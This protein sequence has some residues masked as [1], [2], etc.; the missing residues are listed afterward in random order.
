MRNKI[1]RLILYNT[2]GF[3]KNFWKKI[4]KNFSQISQKKFFLGNFQKFRVRHAIYRFSR[5]RTRCNR[6]KIVST[7]RYIYNRFCFPKFTFSPIRLG[8]GVNLTPLSISAGKVRDG[9][10]MVQ[11]DEKQVILTNKTVLSMVLGVLGRF[12]EV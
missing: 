5:R 6:L 9:P 10:Q 3:F 2:I 12:L 4:F 11:M 7:T 1:T 8:G